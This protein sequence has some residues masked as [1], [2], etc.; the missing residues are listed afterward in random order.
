MI[1]T[2]LSIQSFLG[3]QGLTWAGGWL[4]LVIT[5]FMASVIIHTTL[6]MFGHA[7]AVK[8]LE[9]YAKSEMLQAGATA[10]LAIF[11]VTILTSAIT[12]TSSLIPGEIACGQKYRRA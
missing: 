5:A 10:V 8:E 3:G 2:I 11:L 7:F 1:I 6:M 12:V 9:A 4:P